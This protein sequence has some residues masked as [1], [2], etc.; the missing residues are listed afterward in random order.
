MKVLSPS[1]TSRARVCA[2]VRAVYL[3]NEERAKRWFVD[4]VFTSSTG[5]ASVTASAS[6]PVVGSAWAWTEMVLAT[7][8]GLAVRNLAS[9]NR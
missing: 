8:L 4:R 1:S 2:Y 3:S 5:M 9:T 7:A 6:V